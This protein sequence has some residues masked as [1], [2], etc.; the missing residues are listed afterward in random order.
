MYLNYKNIVVLVILFFYPS[1]KSAENIFLYKGTFSRTIEIEELNKFN[2]TRK[3]SNKLKSL[4]KITN[5]NDKDLHDFLSYKIEV[6][7]K[8]E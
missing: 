3:P 7:L 5:L 8:N 1:A 2:E 4:M 6:P